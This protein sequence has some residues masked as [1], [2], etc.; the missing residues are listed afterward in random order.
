MN[1]GIQLQ[2]KQ[3]QATLLGRT[4]SK[5]E[6]R[7]AEL[8]LVWHYCRSASV[9]CVLR[10]VRLRSNE[11]SSNHGDTEPVSAKANSMIHHHSWSEKVYNMLVQFWAFQ[12]FAPRPGC[13][14]PSLSAVEAKRL[15]MQKTHDACDIDMSELELAAAT[16]CN[17]V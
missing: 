4:C 9:C 15:C 10:T 7:P 11:D 3:P 2:R 8:H 16:L 12:I 13:Y 6:S 17:S 14:H 5:L 1:G